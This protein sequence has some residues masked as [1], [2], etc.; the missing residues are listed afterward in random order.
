MLIVCSGLHGAPLM[1]ITQHIYILSVGILRQLDIPIRRL[2]VAVWT[3][4]GGHVVRLIYDVGPVSYGHVGDSWRH[5]ASENKNRVLVIMAT[6]YTLHGLGIFNSCDL[7]AARLNVYKRRYMLYC[8]SNHFFGNKPTL[9]IFL[10]RRRRDSK[11]VTWIRWFCGTLRTREIEK[12][13]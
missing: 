10:G 7:C 1:A 8:L 13:I 3:R 5:E 2:L 12:N 11:L 4:A 6:R 9:C